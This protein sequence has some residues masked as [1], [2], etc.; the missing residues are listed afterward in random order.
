MCL[1]LPMAVQLYP[2]SQWAVGLCHG[3]IQAGN[4]WKASHMFES[5][6]KAVEASFSLELGF[7][8]SRN[9]LCR[10]DLQTPDQKWRIN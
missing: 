7:G 1:G 2:H 10:F 3:S 9:L 5:G 4:I 8:T 6:R